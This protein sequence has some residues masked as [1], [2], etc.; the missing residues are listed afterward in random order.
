MR[1]V[2]GL[3]LGQLTSYTE[4]L[5]IFFIY[6]GQLMAYSLDTESAVRVI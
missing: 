4:V 6:S 3:N 2:L 5:M 1:E